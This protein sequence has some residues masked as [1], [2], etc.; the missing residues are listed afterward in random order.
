[1]TIG[2]LS[3][4]AHNCEEKQRLASIFIDAVRD[5]MA[6]Q[7]REMV[8]LVARGTGLQ[9]FDM[10][11]HLARSKRDKAKVLYLMHLREHAC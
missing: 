6:L 11:L 5:V 10:A 9:R 7:D 2:A 8:E 3:L 4:K 1:M